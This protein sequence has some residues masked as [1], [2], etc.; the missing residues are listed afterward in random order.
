[1]RARRRQPTRAPRE[2]TV[3]QF[4]VRRYDNAMTQPGPS[5]TPETPAPETCTEH[6]QSVKWHCAICH[7]PLCSACQPVGYAH[8]VY[9]GECLNRQQTQPAKQRSAPLAKVDA[10]STGVRVAAWLFIISAIVW[11]G[12]GLLAA[13]VALISQHYVPL[14]ATIGNPLVVLDD[15]PGSRGLVGWIAL[16]GLLG[17]VVQIWIGLGLLNCIAAARRAV[18]FFAWLEVL[19]ALL[20]WTIV[21]V[22]QQGFWDIPVPALC[23]IIFFSRKD[24]K[25]QFQ[26]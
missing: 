2:F 3:A 18:L 22:A 23:L 1:V 21:A 9:H 10:P 5:A 20:G 8:Q 16:L 17:A 26:P 12:I 11:L 6:Q 25:K 24:V 13:G 7:K 19:A 14:A 15:I 4:Q